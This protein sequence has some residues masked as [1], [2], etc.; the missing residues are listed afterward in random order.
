MILQTVLMDPRIRLGSLAF[1]QMI[2]P[3]ILEFLLYAHLNLSP[4]PQQSYYLLE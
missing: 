3:R 1:L 2:I 4:P